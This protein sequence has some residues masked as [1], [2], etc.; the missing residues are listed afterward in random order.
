MN[1]NDLYSAFNEVDDD[2]LERSETVSR[3]KKKTVWLKWSAIAAC[4]AVL[5]ASAEASSGLV[6]NLLAP[7]Y[8]GAQTE[9]VD[10]I[11]VPVGASATVAGYT[12]TADAI[13]G[14]RYNCA[15]VY[16]LRREDG[17]PL[18]EMLGFDKYT[19]SAREGVGGGNI[20]CRRSED[21]LKY[22]I[23]E[24]WASKDGVRRYAKVAFTNLICHDGGNETILA[25]GTWELRF[26]VRYK[27]TTVKL[28]VDELSVT[29][30]K[31]Y[32]YQIHD[33]YLSPIGI[34]MDLT[35]PVS[36]NGADL[37]DRPFDR[38]MVN[39]HVSVILAE[40]SRIDLVDTNCGVSTE[41]GADIKDVHYGA[42]FDQP[43]PKDSIKALV[44]C[45]TT[46]EISNAQ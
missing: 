24:R 6:S 18:P 10:S 40:D 45:D 1:R 43:I 25:E 34:Y 27:D 41:Y 19:N 28:P 15:I 37:F 32:S 31:G 16:A 36:S 14:D 46:Y 33:I 23:I 26:T 35:S 8:G 20:E 5:V 21:G 11:G 7:L 2:I 29:D 30:S 22:H 44:I 9:L 42:I 3:S 12:L 13:I 4:L 39:F 38:P 17:Q